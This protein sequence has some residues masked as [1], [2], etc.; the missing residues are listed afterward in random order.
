MK[1]DEMAREVGYWVKLKSER[2]GREHA[3]LVLAK[4]PKEAEQR[5][6]RRGTYRVIEVKKAY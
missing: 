1:E 5:A 2:T 4:T 3:R 6:N